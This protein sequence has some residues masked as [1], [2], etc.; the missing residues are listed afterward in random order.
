MV[1]NIAIMDTVYEEL[2]KR[3]RP[4]ESFSGE[5]KRL[6][7]AKGD[8]ADFAGAWKIAPEELDKMKETLKRVKRASTRRVIERVT[9]RA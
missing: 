8:I 6:M 2:A 4:N 9:T 1:K 5:I 7:A 3:K